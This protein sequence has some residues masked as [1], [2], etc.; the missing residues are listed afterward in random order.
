MAHQKRMYH[1]SLHETEGSG[2]VGYLRTPELGELVGFLLSTILNT[3]HNHVEIWWE[4]VEEGDERERQVC[5]MWGRD[6]AGG[7]LCCAFSLDPKGAVSAYYT[8]RDS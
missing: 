8:R 1:A 7:D 4:E 5:R 3:D 2:V 6:Q